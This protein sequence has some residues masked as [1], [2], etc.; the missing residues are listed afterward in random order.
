[1]Y[2]IT[3]AE[4]LDTVEACIQVTYTGSLDSAV[5]LYGSAVGAIGPYVNLTIESGT[6]MGPFPD[7]AGFAADNTD[8]SGTLGAFA[9]A[10]TNFANGVVV[11][12]DAQTEWSL[13]DIV[14]FRFSL[15]LQDNP[16]ASGLQS[17]LHSFTWEAQNV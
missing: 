12:P 5:S 1:M 15:E 6:G 16:L 3:D 10:H 2:T 14:V 8:Y 4:P 11:N 13:G 7:C 17:G 9:A